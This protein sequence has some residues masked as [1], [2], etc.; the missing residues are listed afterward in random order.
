MNLGIYINSFGDLE[1]MKYISECINSAINNNRLKDASIFYNDI[2][3][4]PFEIK[5]GSF[6]STDIW[7]FSGV[8]IATS[9]E[10]LISACNIVNNIQIFYYYGWDKSVNVLALLD[11][12]NTKNISIICNSEKD[13]LEF[14]RLTGRKP[15][16]VCEN[17][18]DILTTLRR[19]DNGCS[20]N[21]KNVCRA[22]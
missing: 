2:G 5:C 22:K 19:C 3:Y 4:N 11:I 12:L 1:Q 14:Y 20:K 8:L 13:S 16:A 17:Y 15:V 10:C 21:C 18:E 9:L 6:N 7:N